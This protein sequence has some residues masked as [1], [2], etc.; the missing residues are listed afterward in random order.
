MKRTW[1]SILV[2]GAVDM[3][4]LDI[5]TS[6]LKKLLSKTLYCFRILL[7]YGSEFLSME[8]RGTEHMCVAII[9]SVYFFCTRTLQEIDVWCVSTYS[10]EDVHPHLEERVG[11]S[12]RESLEKTY[13]RFCA[14]TPSLLVLGKYA[15]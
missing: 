1:I 3:A 11:C 7:Q 9:E 12:S 8:T 4:D 6:S 10:V 5:D 14:C 2:G 15:A 13:S